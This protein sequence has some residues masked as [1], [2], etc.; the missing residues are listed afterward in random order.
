MYQTDDVDRVSTQTEFC[1]YRSSDNFSSRRRSSWQPVHAKT[2]E[3]LASTCHNEL[4]HYSRWDLK[5]ND[6]LR[7]GKTLCQYFICTREEAANSVDRW[8]CPSSILLREA[9]LDCAVCTDTS[10]RTLLLLM[11][12]KDFDPSSA[13]ESIRTSMPC[14]L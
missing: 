11:T 13:N 7:D 2:L 6:P 10:V 1:P 3:S 9:A 4:L 8:E 5:N 12:T 14:Q